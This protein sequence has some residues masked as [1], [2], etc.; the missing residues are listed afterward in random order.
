VAAKCVE[1]IVVYD[2]RLGR[3][4]PMDDWVY[5]GLR[6]I[7]EEQEQWRQQCLLKLIELDEAIKDVERQNGYA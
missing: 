3:K 2:Y 6:R 4:A 1:E 5:G 7:F